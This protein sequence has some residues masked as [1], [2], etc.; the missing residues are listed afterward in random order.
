MLKTRSPT[1]ESKRPKMSD[2]VTYIEESTFLNRI[3]SKCCSKKIISNI[4]KKKQL[5]IFVTVD[6]SLKSKK[7]DTVTVK[8]C[9][10]NVGSPFNKVIDIVERHFAHCVLCAYR[11]ITQTY[12][13]TDFRTA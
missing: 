6:F 1:F 10:I 11:Y 13:C 7:N 5:D 12:T 8:I 4:S 2:A 3:F 9:L